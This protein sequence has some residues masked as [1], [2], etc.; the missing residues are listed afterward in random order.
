[1]SWLLF[2]AFFFS[3]PSTIGGM[4]AFFFRVPSCFLLKYSFIF[5]GGFQRDYDVA[6]Y[7]LVGVGIWG[8]CAWPYE[9]IGG[10]RGVIAAIEATVIWVLRA[11]SKHKGKSPVIPSVPTQKWD[12]RVAEGTANNVYSD[13]NVPPATVLTVAAA[14]VMLCCFYIYALATNGRPDFSK[15]ETYLFYF[16]GTFVQIVLYGRNVQHLFTGTFASKGFWAMAVAA[17]SDDLPLYD[18]KGNVFLLSWW[19]IN[20]RL[21]LE[22]S[23]N[24]AGALLIHLVIPLQLAG[25]SENYFDFLLNSCATIFVLELDDK[26]GVTF[27]LGAGPVKEGHYAK[28]E[29]SDEVIEV[30]DRG[31]VARATFGGERAGQVFTNGYSGVGYYPDTCAEDEGDDTPSTI[32]LT[33]SSADDEHHSRGEVTEANVSV[34]TSP[35]QTL[36]RDSSS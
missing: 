9:C 21:A 33:I 31:F 29:A 30:R 16:A 25:T 10:A 1:M 18:E 17:L 26:E 34:R 6:L 12:Q 36:P 15:T 24:A 5:L 4:I 8:L 19:N 3:M 11:V 28:D 35:P 14:Q 27:Q 7:V 13:L 20:I 2:L 23:I 32:H 22:V